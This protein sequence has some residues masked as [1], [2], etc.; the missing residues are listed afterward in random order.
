[1]AGDFEIE[2]E[3]EIARDASAR[4]V[5]ELRDALH[6][7]NEE[8]TGFRD[9]QSLSCFLRDGDGNLVA[10]IDGFSWGGYA[11]VEYLWVEESYRNRGLG[12]R[13]LAAAEDEA[14][15]RECV[16]MI[17]DTHEFQAPWL[18]PRLGYELVGATNDTPRGHRQF[19]Y[20]KQLIEG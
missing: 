14:R 3:I 9:G 10:G 4:D 11:R 5:S 18:Y 2:I 17:L 7:Y 12:R 6:R 1:V 8:A 15:R 19:L 16:T 20:Q 13:L